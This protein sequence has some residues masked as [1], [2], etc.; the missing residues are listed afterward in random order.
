[1]KRRMLIGVIVLVLRANVALGQNLV[2]NIEGPWIYHVDT[3]FKDESGQPE[4]VLIAMS[5]S[6]DKHVA[7]FSTGD[8]FAIGKP[9]VYCVGFDG[10]CAPAHSGSKSSLPG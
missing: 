2:I 6:V 5:P 1:M 7:S 4:S 10:L 9:G 3:Q 8:G